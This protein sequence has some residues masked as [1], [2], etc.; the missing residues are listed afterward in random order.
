[1]LRVVAAAVLRV[2]KVVAAAVV[3]EFSQERM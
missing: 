2:L 3:G 1:L